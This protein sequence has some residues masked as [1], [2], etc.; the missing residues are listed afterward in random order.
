MLL[1][2]KCGKTQGK[3]YG[4][5]M[6][7]RETTPGT[8]SKIFISAT[9]P[10]AGGGEIHGSIFLARISLDSLYK[11]FGK[12]RRDWEEGREGMG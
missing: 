5:L 1:A 9:F 10:K 6:E 2:R 4:K 11:R 7:K 8:E 3:I 12:Q